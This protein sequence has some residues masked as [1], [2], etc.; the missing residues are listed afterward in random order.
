MKTIGQVIEIPAERVAVF[1][2]Q[3]RSY[4]APALMAELEQSIKAIGQQVEIIV[5]PLQG[6]PA[7]DYEL[8]DG[9]RRLRVCKK[10]GLP[11]RATVRRVTSA[12]DQFLTAVTVNFARAD[13]TILEIAEAIERLRKHPRFAAIKDMQQQ[14]VEIGRAFGR[15]MH[16]VYSHEKL[17]RLAPELKQI[18]SDDVAE[19][20]RLPNR[21]AFVLAPLPHD[22]QLR[23]WQEIKTRNLTRDHA[24]HFINLNRQV[25]PLGRDGRKA[26]DRSGVTVRG[27]INKA[28]DLMTELR[29]SDLELA[30]QGRSREEWRGLEMRLGM[31]EREI[32]KMLEVVQRALGEP[33]QRKV[34]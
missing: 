11:V 25:K 6:D 4:F 10:L 26:P 2:G 15:G 20:D 9:E 33:I 29:A 32:Q 30:F 18:L 23:L 19:K 1:K 28:I 22:E 7:H 21:L 17:L 13:H 34:A 3:P 16:W 12:D 31:A 27:R 24:V 14:A 5:K 8:I